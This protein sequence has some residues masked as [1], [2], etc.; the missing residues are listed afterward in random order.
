MRKAAAGATPAAAAVTLAVVSLTGCGGS[1]APAAQTGT[2]Q[3]VVPPVS[4][5]AAQAGKL[6]QATTYATI[7]AA[8]T[9]P[10]RFA[11]TNGLVVH[12]LAAQIV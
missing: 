12:P 2:Q 10:S 4:V 6:P 11:V 3:Y 9:D 7:P 5:S 8:P 1:P